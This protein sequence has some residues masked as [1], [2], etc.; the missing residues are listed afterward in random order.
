MIQTVFALITN[1][2]KQ[3]LLTQEGEG[4][5]YGKW[6]LPGGH[7][8]L[9]EDAIAAVR[10]ET[11]EETGGLQINVGPLV[12][13]KVMDNSE[14]LGRPEED[15]EKIEIMIFKASP[16]SGEIDPK[17]L[18]EELAIKWL[19]PKEAAVLPLRWDWLA[20]FITQA[21]S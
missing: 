19:S 4:R 1:P 13:K 11:V 14:Y 9:A 5:A 8:D 18:S 6:G 21:V 17:K 7:V 3:V 12:L 16:D 15:G 10:R 2:Q 20:D